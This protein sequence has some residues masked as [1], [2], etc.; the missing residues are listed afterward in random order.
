MKFDI[1]EVYLPQC[2]NAVD[3]DHTQAELYLKHT[4]IGDPP[5]DPVIEELSDLPTAE[6]HR[7]LK[8]GIEIEEDV[9]KRAPSVFREFFNDHVGEPDWIDFEAYRPAIL[10]FHTNTTNILVAFV[11]AVL[12]EGFSTLISKSFATTGRVLNPNT[13]RRRLMQNNRHLLETYMP[14]GLKRYGDGWKLCTRL[15]FIHA[16]VRYLLR[17]AEGVWNE[18]YYGTPISAAHLGYASTVFSMR[19]LDYSKELGVKFSEEEEASLMQLWRYASYVMGIPESILY[20][21]QHSARALWAIALRCEPPPDSDAVLMANALINAIPLTAGIDDTKKR[22]KVLNLAFT[23]SRA[24][25]G[26]D[27]AGKLGFPKKNIVGALPLWRMKNSIQRAFRSDSATRQENFGQM[28]EVAVY[29]NPQR[30]Y[31]MPDHYKSTQSSE[32]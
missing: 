28:L 3:F 13:A 23:L 30:A 18:N 10:A 8:A 15:R 11:T 14:G 21:D 27:L 7:F 26:H 22:N 19:L 31:L 20:Q 32:W 17:H 16:R 29:D 25:I 24:L 1:P 6:L 2:T 12:I 4:N 9:L 5:L